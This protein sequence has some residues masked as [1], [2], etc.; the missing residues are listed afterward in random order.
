MDVSI[1]SP[2]NVSMASTT[3]YDLWY[4]SCLVTP[5]I[6]PHP[7][8]SITSGWEPVSVSSRSTV[9]FSPQTGQLTEGVCKAGLVPHRFPRPYNKFWS[10]VWGWWLPFCSSFIQR[11]GAYTALACLERQLVFTCQDFRD[12]SCQVW[13]FGHVDIDNDQDPPG[14]VGTELLRLDLPT[15]TVCLLEEKYWLAQS[16]IALNLTCWQ[17][18]ELCRSCAPPLYSSG[19]ACMTLTMTKF[20]LVELWVRNSLLICWPAQFTY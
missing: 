5:L 4:R 16:T 17:I 14:E 2:N 18:W 3:S 20:L 6:V 13:L 7:V 19:Q 11:C 1:T 8:P 15:Y 12:W 9:R 10:V